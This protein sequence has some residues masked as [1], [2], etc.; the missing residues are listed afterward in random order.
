M[1][2]LDTNQQDPP[3]AE[4]MAVLRRTL[5]ENGHQRYIGRKE[6]AARLD[7]SPRS[8]QDQLPRLKA[9]GLRERRV[10]QGYRYL[11]SN[12]DAILLRMDA[13]E[14]DLDTVP[15]PPTGDRS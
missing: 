11:Q 9:L 4:L 10:G 7:I 12:V 5:A 2:N 6:L 15:K 14:I 8:L 13:D 3:L 1:T